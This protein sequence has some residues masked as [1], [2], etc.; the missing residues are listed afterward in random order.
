MIKMID[1][2]EALKNTTKWLETCS[3]EEFLRTFNQLDGEYGEGVS[4]GEL[5]DLI[6]DYNVDDNKDV[7]AYNIMTTDNFVFGAKTVKPSH[8]QSFFTIK[9][10]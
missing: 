6:Q 7:I 10:I 2:Y 9:V 3:Q 1:K 4:L 5:V 8:P